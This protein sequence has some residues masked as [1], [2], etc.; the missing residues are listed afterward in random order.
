MAKENSNNISLFKRLFFALSLALVVLILWD[1]SPVGGNIRFYRKWAE[2]GSQPIQVQSWGGKAWYEATNP[3]PSM[4]RSTGRYCTPIEAERA[5]Y[6]ASR[7]ERSFPNLEKA[8][9]PIPL[10]NGGVRYPNGKEVLWN[11]SILYPEGTESGRSHALANCP[12][13]TQE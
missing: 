5:G 1:L 8:C 12:D 10:T 2:C 13:Y 6:S 9:E 4:F 3:Y 11:G 7:Y